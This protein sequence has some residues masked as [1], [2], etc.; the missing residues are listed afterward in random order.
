MERKITCKNCRKDFKFKSDAPSRHEIENDV[1]RYF[2]SSCSHCHID[3]EYHVNEIM[4]EEGKSTILL[5]IILALSLAIILTVILLNMGF[6]WLVTLILPGFIYYQLKSSN[7]K[8]VQLFN[9]SN[10]SRMRP[11]NR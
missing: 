11:K 8:S 4:A 10:I 6:I 3:K 9:Q 2:Y 7:Q 5:Y 1:G